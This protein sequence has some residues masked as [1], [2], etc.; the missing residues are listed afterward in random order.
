MWGNTIWDVL[1]NVSFLTIWSLLIINLALVIGGAVYYRKIKRAKPNPPLPEYPTVSILVPAH[2]EELVIRKT[3]LSL[4][5]LDYPTDRYEILVI[6]DNSD[7]ETGAEIE[8]IRAEHPDRRIKVLTTTAV[9]GGKGKSNALN[10]ALAVADGE[11][12]SVYDADNT[13]EP[14]ALRILVETLVADD[15]LGAVTGKIRTRNKDATLL[16][17]L[18]NIETLTAQHTISTGRCC[19]FDLAMLPG[20]NF[21]IRKSIVDSAGGW[22]THALTEDTELSYR[23]Y[24]NGYKI[25]FLPIAV[26][27]EQ[28]PQRLGN[29]FKQR[30]RWVRGNF[31][32]AVKNIRHLFSRRMGA[33]RLD[34]IHYVLMNLG[35]LVAVT[36]S[37]I[38]AILG[39]LDYI[40]LTTWLAHP[41]YWICA[42]VVF[43]FTLLFALSREKEEF[44]LRNILR[45]IIV[46]FYCK[47]WHAV[48]Y[49]SIFLGL[50]RTL[51]GQRDL[52]DKTKRYREEDPK[53]TNKT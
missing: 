32:V 1:F 43:F 19:F 22:D 52:W 33:A 5:Q 9:N 25:R 40:S 20:T 6:N 4:L 11:L 44:T 14:N 10:L 38:I 53:E 46:Y 3:L 37:D 45:C 31:Y 8:R 47:L 41:Y 30:S 13:P 48:V 28:E 16:T 39:W 2:N 49:Y 17:K 51:T 15:R 36:I 21:V 35:M 12:L 34:L 18:I 26:S 24:R 7:D 23:V 42:A 29:W 27:W 50:R